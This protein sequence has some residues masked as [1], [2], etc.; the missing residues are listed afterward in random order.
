MIMKNIINKKL[1]DKTIKILQAAVTAVFIGIVVFAL[2]FFVYDA[3]TKVR[4]TQI[5]QECEEL[6]GF[7]WVKS[8]P[9]GRYFR[10]YMD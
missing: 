10:R 1:K 4:P 6:K 5:H 9:S 8:N 3:V 2:S 7:E